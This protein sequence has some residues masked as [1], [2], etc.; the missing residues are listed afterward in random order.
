MSQARPDS[1][2]LWRGGMEFT[3]REKGD[4]RRVPAE[5]LYFAQVER[6][7]ARGEKLKEEEEE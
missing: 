2:G 7:D 4:I 6:R 3:E 1:S 5:L